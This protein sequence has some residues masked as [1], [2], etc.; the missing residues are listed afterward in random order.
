[1]T[2]LLRHVQN[3]AGHKVADDDD[4]GD[5]DDGDYSL[6]EASL[7]TAVVAAHRLYLLS[8]RIKSAVRLQLK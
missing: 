5:D 7:T 2:S 4:D 1:M 8:R 3:S 6:D